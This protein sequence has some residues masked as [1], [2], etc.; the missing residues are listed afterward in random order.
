MGDCLIVLPYTS[1]SLA[2]S[3]MLKRLLATA[4]SG[5]DFFFKFSHFSK[6]LKLATSINRSAQHTLAHHTNVQK[7]LHPIY[8][9]E[10]KWN[11]LPRR[12]CQSLG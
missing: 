5:F 10:Q 11:P 6:I 9:L 3:Q 2:Y 1:T 8:F 4:A 12:Q 7:R